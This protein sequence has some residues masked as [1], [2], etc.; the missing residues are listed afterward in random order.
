MKRFFYQRDGLAQGHLIKVLASHHVSPKGRVALIDVAGEKV[1]IG[2]TPERISA[3]GQIKSSKTL[4][5]I[6]ETEYTGMEH[7]VFE[8]LLTKSFK[9]RLRARKSKGVTGG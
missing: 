6:A 2:I 9:G 1:L 4:E 7:N 8:R 5:S 3:L